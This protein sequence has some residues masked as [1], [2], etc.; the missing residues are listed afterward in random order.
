MAPLPANGTTRFFYDYVTGSGPFAKEHTLIQRVT[1]TPDTDAETPQLALSDFL[2]S[3]GEG[4]FALGWQ[5]LRVRVQA[6]GTNFSLPVTML[7]E[8][9][10]FEGSASAI[11]APDEA[12]EWTWQGRSQTSGRHVDFSLY[13]LNAILPATFR[14]E[15]G[16][17]SPAW[18]AASVAS[19]NANNANFFKA[20]DNS[21][22]VWYQYV[23]ANFNSYWESEIRNG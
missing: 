3:I 22:A 6:A 13:G 19:L 9:Q 16:G 8:L 4:I 20:I 23:N 17:S 7:T 12:R 2:D 14:Y 15:A 21:P 11:A 1:G 5:I 10:N 18:V